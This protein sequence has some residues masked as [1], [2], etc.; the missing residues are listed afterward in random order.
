MF[1]LDPQVVDFYTITRF[2]GEV[3]RQQNVKIEIH[4]RI[5]Q[6]RHI[7]SQIVCLYFDLDMRC[8]TWVDCNLR[9]SHCKI[10]HV[11]RP[12]GIEFLLQC[13]RQVGQ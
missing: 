10:Q 3:I 9:T 8:Q 4:N 13:F 12:I 11:L 7:E 5:R 6:T 1:E 2:F